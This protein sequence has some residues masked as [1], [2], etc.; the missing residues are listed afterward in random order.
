MTLPQPNKTSGFDELI[1]SPFQ[2]IQ[3]DRL[4]LGLSAHGLDLVLERS[5]LAL[6]LG[7]EFAPTLIKHT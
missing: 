2:I 3:M 5:S 1:G 4:V 6:G 7:Q